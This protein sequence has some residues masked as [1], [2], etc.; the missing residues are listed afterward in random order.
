M[1]KKGE[2]MSKETNRFQNLSKSVE[3]LILHGLVDNSKPL[4][5]VLLTI[6]DEREKGNLSID[7]DWNIHGVLSK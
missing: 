3:F 5:E 2:K 1:T 6:L 4:D 7:D